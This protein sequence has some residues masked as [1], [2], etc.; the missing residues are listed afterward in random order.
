MKVSQKEK[1][2]I[3]TRNTNI[4]AFNLNMDTKYTNALLALPK[5]C[6][7]VWV[8]YICVRGGVFF[9]GFVV[10]AAEED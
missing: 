2:S 5:I 8:C 6:L 3:L 1:I 9:L 4:Q 10:V 7:C